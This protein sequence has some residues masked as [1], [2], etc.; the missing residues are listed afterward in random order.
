M[1]PDTGWRMIFDRF[2]LVALLVTAIMSLALGVTLT[3]WWLGP[4]EP[5][6]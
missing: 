6:A 4:V 5:G 3:L 1:P 2:V